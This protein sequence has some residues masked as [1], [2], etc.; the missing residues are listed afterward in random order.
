[1][2]Q[3]CQVGLNDDDDDAEPRLM[4]MRQA[5]PVDRLYALR[6]VL[7]SAMVSRL[8]GATVDACQVCGRQEA[9]IHRIF[10]IAISHGCSA[11]DL[12]QVVVDDVGGS[13]GFSVAERIHVPCQWALV[14]VIRVCEE[15]SQIRVELALCSERHTS[16]LGMP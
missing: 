12:T 7:I 16:R 1:M 15:T 3:C 5:S 8:C 2:G 6:E 14:R 4:L 9:A 11:M 10:W 13:L